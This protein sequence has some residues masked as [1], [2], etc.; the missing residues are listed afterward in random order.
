M[1]DTELHQTLWLSL[2]D[3]QASG[4]AGQK[5]TVR[6]WLKL[7]GSRGDMDRMKQWVKET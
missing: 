3:Q 1:L 5:M 4:E 6:V 2:W 7:A